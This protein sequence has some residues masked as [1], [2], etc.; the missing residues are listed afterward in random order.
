[1]ARNGH[2]G[3]GEMCG[4]NIDADNLREPAG[5]GDGLPTHAAAELQHTLDVRDRLSATRE[6]GLDCRQASLS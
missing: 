3:Q 6:K 2:L 1:M 5:Q 4:G